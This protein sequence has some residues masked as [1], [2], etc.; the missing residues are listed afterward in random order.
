MLF[1]RLH[2]APMF[3]GQPSRRDYAMG[4]VWCGLI[5]NAQERGN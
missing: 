5:L 1:D 3:S 4:L 2:L